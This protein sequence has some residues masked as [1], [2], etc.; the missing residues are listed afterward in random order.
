MFKKI[1]IIEDEMFV[2][3]HLKKIVTSLGYKVVDTFFSAE[4]FLLESNWNFDVAIIDI[5]LSG[6]LTGLDVAK[7]LRKKHKPFFF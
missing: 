3:M 2:L 7:E 6:K 4:D 5:L 1:I